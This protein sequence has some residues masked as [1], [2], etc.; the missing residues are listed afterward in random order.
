MHPVIENFL[1][2]PKGQKLG[3]LGVVF[4]IIVGLLWQ[5]LLKSPL[6][7]LSSLKE[8]KESLEVQ[9][10]EQRRI[11]K[12]LPRFTKE[13]KEFDKKLEIVLLELPDSKEIPELLSSISTYAIDT[14]LEI[15]KFS[16]QHEQIKEF[17]AEVPVNIELEGT[18]HQLATFFDEVGHLSRIVNIDEIF[19]NIVN[20][21]KSEVLVRASCRATTF[22]YLTDE[23]RKAMEAPKEEAKA[24]RKHRKGKVS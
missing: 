11:A 7:E 13:V 20:E 12:E 10:L 14:G 9:I 3:I 15:L 2:R 23:E 4:L 8:K 5:Y 21:T 24:G 1:E 16:P 17:Y 18:F 22:R 6:T 19:V